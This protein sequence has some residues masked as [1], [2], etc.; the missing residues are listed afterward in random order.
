MSGC[1]AC[2]RVCAVSSLSVLCVRN[3]FFPFSL[4]ASSCRSVQ[5]RYQAGLDWPTESVAI[6]QATMMISPFGTLKA[7][8]PVVEAR[9]SVPE[10]L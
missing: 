5:Y 8:A 7:D 1:A 9:Q 2:L 4:H 6:K 3:V 10:C